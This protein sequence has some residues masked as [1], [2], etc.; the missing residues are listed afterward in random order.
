MLHLKR[1]SAGSGKTYELAKTYIKFLL[2]EKEHEKNRRL[3]DPRSLKE[4]LGSI[5]AVTF[6]VK[7]TAEMKQRIVEKLSALAHADEALPQDYDKIDY[8][9]DF[10]EEIPGSDAIQIADLAKKALN[11]L[12]LN[13]S[14]FRVQTI[15]AFFQ[16]ILHTFAYE[17]SLDDNF[18]MEI[19]TDFVT[20]VGLDVTLDALSGP[21]MQKNVNSETFHWLNTLMSQG[22]TANRW[23]VFARADNEYSLYRDIINK[24]KRLEKEEF[25]TK[26][27]A[28][29]R[30]FDGLDRSFREI[31]D[32]I[33]EANLGALKKLAEERRKAAR[34]IAVA[35]HN[36][37]LEHSDLY[38][39]LGK[40]VKD[41]DCKFDPSMLKDITTVKS[42]KS[43]KEGRS[44]SKKGLEKLSVTGAPTAGHIADLDDAFERW[45]DANNDMA[46]YLEENRLAVC[47]WLAYR[48]ALPELM[49][50]FEIVR[51]KREYLD[52]TNTLEISDTT[53]IL[54]RII[55]RQDA[56]FVYERMGSRLN[57]FLID[58]FQDTSRMQWDNLYPLLE[59]SESRYNDNLII[60]DAK[61]SIY[62]F[63]NA[64]Y[65]LITEEVERGFHKVVPYTGDKEPKDWARENTN[66]RSHRAVVE[67]NNRIFSTIIDFEAGS[68]NKQ[69]VFCDRIK[70]IYETAVQAIPEKTKKKN[71]GYVD[72]KIYPA[73]SAEAKKNFEDVGNVN[74][75]EPGF[76]ELPSLIMNLR[77]RGY[78]FRDIGV[79]V[80]VHDQGKAVVR[81]IAAF[82]AE[83]PDNQIPVISQENLLVSTALSVRLVIN[84]LETAMHATGEKLPS[85]PV[86]ND[87]VD[88]EKLFR[89]LRSL[90]SPALPSIIE[91]VIDNF[92]T[93]EQRN[94][95]APFIAAFQDAVL[96]YTTTHTSDIGSFLK[97]WERKADVLCINS[98][99]ESDGVRIHTIHG[100]K[101]LEYNCVILPLADFKFVPSSRHTEWKW[102]EPSTVVKKA[103]L[104]PPF[105]PVTTVQTLQN[106][107][108]AD[109]WRDYCEEVALDELNKMYVGFTR[110]VGELYVYVPDKT[111]VAESGARALEE[112]LGDELI[113]MEIDED[114]AVPLGTLVYT[115]GVPFTPD[116]IAKIKRK[117]TSDTLYLKEYSVY[118]DRRLLRFQ[119]ENN[120]L[121]SREEDADDE[122]ADPRSE[123]TLKHGIMQRINVAGDL[124]KAIRGMLVAGLI[125]RE[126]AEQWEPQLEE[127]LKEVESYG[128]FAP[129]ARVLNERTL[130]FRKEGYLRPDRIVVTP[131]GEA[132]IVDY[133][134]GKPR[135]A[136]KT[137]V[138]QYASRLLST[139]IF[140]DVKAY[141]WYV[142]E[143]KV[144]KVV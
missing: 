133:K 127:A 35:L 42:P 79:L 103:E 29:E 40:R 96:D 8:L 19:D 86:L 5:M 125:T 116:D 11:I 120:L 87:P 12:L 58:E 44:L 20:S 137:Q 53:G 37:G 91:A 74:M 122:E 95:D 124:P 49:V 144:E 61:Q 7:A 2:T 23:N 3:R 107:A 15:D 100:S 39:R 131:S 6:T 89:L 126:Q 25:Q 84:A 54:S 4:A 130:L 140:P 71:P 83:N 9:K 78:A 22:K 143:G 65:K 47:T 128:W 98:P 30:Y 27:K 28:I 52:L 34:D 10:L 132:A 75:G 112:I 70:K 88:E 51:R 92:L 26:R 38:N 141:L 139:G 50:V 82:N 113:N 111:K 32:E 97:W 104:L 72:L 31:F 99:E 77:D 59:E 56:P 115:S 62:R 57:H 109:V 117:D 123:G 13:Y 41:S 48:E 119:E 43:D 114:S 46:G 102:V 81:A 93:E 138:I 105:L 101:G 17:A 24:A 94:A 142:G 14:D 69:R 63:R 136:H 21:E 16:S 110:A 121:P 68:G 108:H 45:V 18:N 76:R 1:A 135:S 55:S 80:R 118:S 66:Y 106:T 67:F 73:L 64:D 33:D 36:L 60:G 85:N 90:Q 134:F 129:G